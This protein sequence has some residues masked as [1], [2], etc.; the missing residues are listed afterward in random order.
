MAKEFKKLIEK[1]SAKAQKHKNTKTKQ[2]L[3]DLPLRKMRKAL[4]LSQE[5]LA[6]KLDVNQ[7]AVSK[8]EARKNIELETLK[9]YAKAVG[10]QLE[11]NLKYPNSNKRIHLT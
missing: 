1:M 11:I 2:M 9:R 8:Q 6:R 7:P 10:A 4:G 3:D 5:E